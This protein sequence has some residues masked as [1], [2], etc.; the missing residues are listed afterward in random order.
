VAPTSLDELCINTIRTLSM[1]AVQK[2][3]SGHPGTPMGLAPVAYTL[4]TRFM[5]HNP[6]NPHWADRDRFVLSAGHAS[7]LLYSLL[8]LTGYDLDLKE[9]QDFR[10][11]QSRTPGHPE[12]GHTPGVEVT[13][14]PLGQGFGMAVGFAL[15]EHLLAARFNKPGHTIV[16]HYVY[17][18]CSD[19]DLMEGVSAEA[20]SVAGFLGLGKLIFFYDDNNISIEGSTN[21]AFTE[22]V[23]QRFEAYGWHIARI[24]GNDLDGI[25]AALEEARAETQRPS[26]IITKTTIAY[27][28]PNKAG[29]AAAHGSPLGEEEVELTKERLGWPP[30]AKFFVPDEALAEFRK[31][32]DTGQQRE[33]EWDAR[34]ASY[35]EAFPEDVAAFRTA[36]AGDLPAG[37]EDTL[38]K[39]APGDKAVSTR[40]AGGQALNALA[41]VL[42]TLVGGAADLA[43][44]TETL[45]KDYGSVGPHEYSGRNLHFGVRE[46]AMGAI[47]NGLAIHGGFIPYCATFLIFSDYMRASIRLASLMQSHSTFIFT[48]DSIGLGEDGPTHQPI[49]HLASL[50]AMPGL[51]LIRPADANET[52]AA[53]A[54]VISTSGPTAMALSR[55]NL[56]I[57]DAPH[58]VVFEGTKRGAYVLADAGNSQ[59]DVILM[60]T[61]SEVQLAVAARATLEDEGIATRVVSM[62]S[63]E[64]FAAQPQAY[65]DEILPPAVRARVSV[66]AASTF[67]W[68]RYVGDAGVAI[69]VDHFGASAP[70]GTVMEKFGFTAENVAQHARDV[71]ARCREGG[72]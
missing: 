9:L 56:P 49:E 55:Q 30:E 16:D 11:W 66:E 2:A 24:D 31:C 12:Y 22:N 25:S 10:Q 14:G 47:T 48:H 38:P 63:W 67:G 6:A 5:H 13:T 4:W 19:G 59:P 32:L 57:L 41:P 60:A 29:T 50:R 1:D 27:G 58:D 70:G 52:A 68:E 45:L 54:V 69:G 7:M 18:I 72:H 43:P 21:L 53:W 65:R 39:F 64:L 62:P 40:V 33:S 8:A 17:G 44:S 23:G 34:F 3:N 51:R 42:P 37:W 61:G 20:A 35:A 46:H 26:L 28:S 71:L 36:L 15:A